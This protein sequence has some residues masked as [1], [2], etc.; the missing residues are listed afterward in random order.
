MR[1]NVQLELLFWLFTALLVIIVQLPIYNSLGPER[2][3]FYLQNTVFILA[4]VT[5]TRYIFLLQ[6]TFLAYRQFLKIAFVFLC[7]PLIFYLVQEINHFQTYIDEQ[8]W[9]ALV[10]HLAYENRNGMIDYIRNQ[11]ILFGTMAVISS[12]LFPFRL[13][14]SVW[15]TYNRGRV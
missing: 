3:P 15:L 9:D 4:A 7:I 13:M 10:G 8:G 14:A 2:Y 1:K 5:V 11:M 6:H 12:V